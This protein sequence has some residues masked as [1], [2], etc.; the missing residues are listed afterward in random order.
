MIALGLSVVIVLIS[1]ALL[2]ALGQAFYAAI[3]GVAIAEVALATLNA[4]F[5][6]YHSYALTYSK[7]YQFQLSIDG[8]VK[9]WLHMTG[10]IKGGTC[11]HTYDS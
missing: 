10:R 4:L 1:D 3:T 11:M 7:Q 6:I 9:K 5:N 8:P 2:R